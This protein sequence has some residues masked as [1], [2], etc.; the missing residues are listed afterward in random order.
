[1]TIEGICNLEAAL[2]ELL[3][4]DGFK[5]GSSRMIK[6]T[7]LAKKL[8]EWI[9][10]N[11]CAVKFFEGTLL[12]N[13]KRCT[14][15]G[16]SSKEGREDSLMRFHKLRSSSAFRNLWKVFL[17]PIGDEAAANDPIFF[18]YLSR[19]L[20]NIYIKKAFPIPSR[21]EDKHDLS[22]TFE[23]E[24]ALRYVAGYVC[25]KLHTKLKAS[26]NPRKDDLLIG[27]HDMID[28]DHE[29]ADDPSESWVHLIDRG[30][31]VYVHDKV[32]QL[33]M[34]MEILIRSHFQKDKAT[35]LPAN[36][37]DK[38]IASILSNDGV[39]F[40]W[41]S[42]VAEL[43]TEDRIVL[44][45]MIANLFLTIRGFAFAGAYVDM[46]KQNARKSL[47]KSQGLRSKINN[48]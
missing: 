26:T 4:D 27:I 33:F 24:N 19:K 32:H 22:L 29:Y 6:A 40:L 18:Q 45:E 17:T 42:I 15:A 30:G 44:L 38:V 11:V 23:E 41:S 36:L 47:Q 25:Y 28:D 7:E 43:E 31:L 35:D 34:K 21:A 3:S 13:F 1:M 20:F 37:K 39:C 46:Y 12:K 10:F 8:H 48:N 9:P 16:V 5:L 14:E 2:E